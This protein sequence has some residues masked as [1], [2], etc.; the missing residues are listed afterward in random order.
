MKRETGGSIFGAKRRFTHCIH[1]LALLALIVPG[2]CESRTIRV[3]QDGT[4]DATSI[5]NGIW[6]AQAQ[7]T[8][9]VSAG[10]YYESPIYMVQLAIH[11]ISE[12]G[13]ER[14]T[15]QLFK[16]SPDDVTVIRMQ[17]II[18][19]C[20]LIGFTIRG[21]S[22]GFVDMGGAVSCSNSALLIKNNIITY[23][24]CANTGGIVCHGAPPPTIEGNLIYGNQ[25]WANGTIGV[26]NCSPLILN[27]T[28]VGNNSTDGTSGICISGDQS[29]PIV[30]NN[31]IAL[32][33]SNADAPALSSSTPMNQITFECNDVWNNTPFNYG[34]TF[35]DQTGLNGNISMD[36][37]FCG[38]AGS[39]NYFL[40]GLSPCAEANTATPCAGA[41]IGLYPVKCEVG[42]K[43]D[44]W[45]DVKAM[46][47]G[48]RR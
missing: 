30:R 31:I 23:N 1:A 5:R 6:L 43:G 46:F 13:P 35:T 17:D 20:S 12:E 45:G 3:K 34:A 27:N 19:P 21:A 37:L 7:D 36:P 47:N 25:Q 26:V 33:S 38:V 44:S 16:T 39:G 28:I 42:V 41:R 48:D 18:G 22:G 14:T 15:I 24:W 32:N 10:Y 2:Q 4:G 29:W 8:V 9:L 40:Q 11:L